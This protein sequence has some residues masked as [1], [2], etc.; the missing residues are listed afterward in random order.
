[1]FLNPISSLFLNLSV[2]LY[3]EVDVIK[4][5]GGTKLSIHFNTHAQSFSQLLGVI[6]KV[7][8]LS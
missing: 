3:N 5:N 4:D 2:L 7:Q 8:D 1:M 6:Q